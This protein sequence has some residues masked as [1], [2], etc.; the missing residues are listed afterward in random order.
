MTHNHGQNSQSSQIIANSNHNITTNTTAISTTNNVANTHNSS[1]TNQTYQRQD[2][3][4]RRSSSEPVQDHAANRTKENIIA[5]YNSNTR[6]GI[7]DDEHSKDSG[8]IDCLQNITSR[9]V[10]I[11]THGVTVFL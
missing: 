7:N 10:R 8:F 3:K 9:E 6:D 11:F 4:N 2:F 1:H 5:I